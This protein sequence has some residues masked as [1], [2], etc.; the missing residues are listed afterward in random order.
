MGFDRHSKDGKQK[1]LELCQIGK[2]LGTY[3]NDF[4]IVTVREKPDFIISNGTINVG[5][6]HELLL[7]STS[8]EKEGF[9]QNISE[10][11]EA[12][13]VK[14]PS[15]P[16]FLVNLYFK[17][18]LSYGISDKSDLIAQLTDLVRHFI[19]TGQLLE[20]NLVIRANKMK[21]SQKS[22]NA[23]FGAY[24]QKS[25]SKDLIIEHIA[26]KERKISNYR[27]NTN[28]PQWLVLV[29]GGIGESSFE[30]CE[31]FHVDLQSDFDKVFLYE[32]F[33]NNLFELK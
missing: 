22:V 13:L 33:N 6:E 28:L 32:D 4:D 10:K 2:L 3:F 7:D 27:Q 11:V 16:N 14:D 19:L 12:A 31:L 30:V 5:L 18:N 9:Y 8:K 17:Q 23:N 24:I 21:H 26:K 1:I 29:I 20:N 25:V 15:I